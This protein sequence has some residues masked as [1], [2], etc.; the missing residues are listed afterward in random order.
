MF[1]VIID[2]IKILPGESMLLFLIFCQLIMLLTTK[3]ISLGT[4]LFQLFV[5]GLTGFLTI[6]FSI[7]YSGKI[8]FMI[9]SLAMFLVICVRTPAKK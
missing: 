9:I 2:F 4:I 3:K 8:I 1:D 5:I 6:L 7:G